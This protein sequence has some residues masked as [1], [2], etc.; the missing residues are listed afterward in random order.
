MDESLLKLAKASSSEKK[1]QLA[2]H[3]TGLLAARPHAADSDQAAL[4]NSMLE[5]VYDSLS[6]N[7]R[8]SMSQALADVPALSAKLAASMAKD[9]LPV[10]KSILERSK[11]LTDADLADIAQ[12]MD[13]G[14]LLAL[15]RREHISNNISK[16]L[17]KRGNKEVRHTVAANLGADISEDDFEMLVKEMPKQ[18]GERIRHLRKSNEELIEDLF[19][20]DGEIPAG[21]ELQRRPARISAKAWLQGIR[22]KKTTLN[23]AVYQ[24][25][26]EHNLLDAVALLSFFSGLDMKYVHNLMV[27]YDSTGIAT[28]CRATGIGAKEY[29]AICK[30]RCKHLKFPESTGSKWLTNYHMLDETDAR[31]LL[32]LMKVKLRVGNQEQAA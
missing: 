31:R 24:M 4:L 19:K 5:G 23:K 26:V 15:A 18:L 25:A 6:L 10:A 13:Q 27:R 7:A 16:I 29:Q 28:V 32:A 1:H 21:S 3:V 22:M 17:V 11:S 9:D 30:E 20:D 2:D 14:H 8:E 12:N